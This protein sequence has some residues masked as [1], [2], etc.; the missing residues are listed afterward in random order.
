MKKLFTTITL[1]MSLVVPVTA[2]A[3]TTQCQVINSLPITITTQGVYCF[4]SHLAT[5]ATTGSAIQINT[6]NVIIDFNGFKLGNL[7]GGVETDMVGV[8]ATDRVNIILKNANIRGFQSGIAISGGSGHRIY[9]SNFDGNFEVAI[10]LGGQ[11][12]VE[13]NTI[14]NAGGRSSTD[15]VAINVTANSSV[16]RNNIVSNFDAA[17]TSYS[18]IGIL[19]SSDQ[20][21]VKDNVISGLVNANTSSYGIEATTGSGNIMAGN[22]VSLLDDGFLLS[23]SDAILRDNI[24]S[25]CTNNYTTSNG[26]VINDA[27]HNY[28]SFP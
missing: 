2:L 9:D 11:G 15:A 4:T 25:S 12:I 7:G 22:M 14:V 13:N 24:A 16:I 8:A 21:V 18:A 3:E 5:S 1:M 6:N 23:D 27:G 19:L 17:T 20:N 10:D 28:P 26:G